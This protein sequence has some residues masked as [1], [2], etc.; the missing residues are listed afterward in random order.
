MKKIF[1]M[2]FDHYIFDLDGTIVD[3]KEIHQ[4]AFND[5][6]EHLNFLK[7]SNKDLI[8]F[9]AL[10]SFKKIQLYNSIN[11]TNIDIDE[12]LKI[13]NTYSISRINQSDFIFNVKIFNLF[14]NLNEDNKKISICSNCTLESIIAILDKA[15][16][17]DFINHDSIFHNKSCEPKP[18]PEIYRLA[19]LNSKIK[20]ENS[21]I[22]EDSSVG[23][24]S[25]LK[26]FDNI[27]VVKILN[28]E[29]LLLL[30]TE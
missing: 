24:E 20:P 26:S 7:I 16:I 10:P 25:A 30:F 19:V 22:F 13:K 15:K 29:S 8:L 6:L 28:P 9:E 2:N 1:N 18:S 21:I 11:K 14:K 5:A 27:N 3:T 12:F 17:L 23:I 4:L